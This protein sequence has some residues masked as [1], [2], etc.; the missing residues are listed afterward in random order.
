MCKFIVGVTAEAASFAT[1]T[2]Y[3]VTTHLSI[4]RAS[5]ST[6]GEEAGS[7]SILCLERVF[8]RHSTIDVDS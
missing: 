1:R 5:S 4:C 3:I 2:R 8:E 7:S 6:L